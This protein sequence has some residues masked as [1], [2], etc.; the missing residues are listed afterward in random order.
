[1]AVTQF[2][3]ALATAITFRDSGGSYALTLSAL[4]ATPAARQSV[5]ADLAVSGAL[6]ADAYDVFAEIEFSSAP[7]AGGVIEFYWA[8]SISATAG[9][10]NAALATGT[11]AAF[12]AAGTLADKLLQLIPIGVLVVT[13][14]AVLQTG[15]V[16]VLCPSLRYGSLIVVNRT[17]QAIKTATTHV[18][19][20]TPVKDTTDV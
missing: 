10:S 14:E 15:R 2:L 7:T 20:M 9:T 18:V 4:A 8:E 1:M 19:T 11:D 3:L 5:K 13:N 16:G 17:S 12:P 6:F